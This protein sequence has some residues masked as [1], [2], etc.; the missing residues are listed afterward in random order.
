MSEVGWLVLSEIP[1]FLVRIM[2]GEGRPGRACQPPTASSQSPKPMAEFRDRERFIP[3]RV[4]DLVGY[5][6]AESGPLRGQT[7]SAAEQD[8]FRRFAR[9][10]SGHVHTIYQAEIRRLKEAY[11]PFDP[12]ADPKPLNP[13][14]PDERAVDLE[15]LFDTFVHL[16]ARANYVRLSRE[17]LERVMQGA[18][19][20]GGDLGGAWEAFARVEVFYRGKGFGKRPLR[21]WRTLWRSREVTVPTFARVA[22]VFKQRPHKRLG[23]A[24]DTANVFLKLFKDIPQM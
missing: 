14:T 22:V 9:S 15:K 16:M 5:L 24:A 2:Q 13:P 6:C 18:S 17:E 23:P 12:D 1:P 4:A 11:A 7:L 10:V 21:S 19:A 8:A 20:G 3:I